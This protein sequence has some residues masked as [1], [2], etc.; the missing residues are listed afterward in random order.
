MKT[1]NQICKEILLN[2]TG[3]ETYDWIGEFDIDNYI[4]ENYPDYIYQKYDIYKCMEKY[5]NYV[6]KYRS[7]FDEDL[8]QYKD[9][10]DLD[11]ERDIGY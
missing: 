5:V 9:Y 6:D 1:L 10:T 3:K 8:D 11:F 2:L 7:I 4:E